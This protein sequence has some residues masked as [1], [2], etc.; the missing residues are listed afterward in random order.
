[1]TN[2]DAL[3]KLLTSPVKWDHNSACFLG[4]SGEGERTWLTNRFLVSCSLNISQLYGGH[5]SG[6][7]LHACLG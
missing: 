4:L 3:T 1:M 7:Y 5:K 2:V 6:H